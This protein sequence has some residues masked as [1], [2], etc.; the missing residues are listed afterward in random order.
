MKAIVCVKYGPPEVLQLQDVEKPTPRNHEVLIRIH[1]TAVTTAACNSLRGQPFASR[2]VTGR[3]ASGFRTPK[4]S[5]LG[6]ELAGE[7]ETVG[8][9]VKQFKVGDPVFGSTTLRLGAYAEYI[10]LPEDGPVAIKPANMTY[11]EAAAVVEGALTALP[12]LR[13][14]AKIQPGQQILIIGASGSTG[15][16]AIQL[17]KYLGAEV[18]AVCSAV[19]L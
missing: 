13:D 4:T 7:I 11:E 2:L 14:L 10:C 1:A 15:T 19:N 17:A 6:F 5:I 18:T 9:E 8:K 12:C 16:A 3:L